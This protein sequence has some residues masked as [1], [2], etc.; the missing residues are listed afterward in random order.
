MALERLDNIAAPGAKFLHHIA[1]GS[2]DPAILA[3]LG[4]SC[5]ALPGSRR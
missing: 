1:N 2:F 5:R 3:A 4:K